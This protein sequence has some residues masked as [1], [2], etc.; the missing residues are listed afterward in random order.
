VG[1]ERPTGQRQVAHQIEHLVPH[2]FVGPAER[3]PDRTVRTED[4]QVAG[5]GRQAAAHCLKPRG[6]LGRQKRASGREF[7]AIGVGRHPQREHLPTDRAG[8]V[9][10]FV[11]DRQTGEPRGRGLD[12]AGIVAHPH[13]R[14]DDDGL[15]G[16]RQIHTTGRVDGLGERQRRAVEAGHLLG[17]HSN[18]AAVDI[19][20]GQRAEQVL[21]HLY[22]GIA[23]GEVRAT[24]SLFTMLHVG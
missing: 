21:D 9:V 3:V 15:D 17:M 14:T 11:L 5:G 12:P 10:E 13:R 6:I 4:E 2:A 8:A 1:V 19:E 22:A 7:R 18:E 16:N 23:S 24:R 20:T